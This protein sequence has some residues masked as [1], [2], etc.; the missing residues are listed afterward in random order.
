MVGPGGVCLPLGLEWAGLL[1]TAAER[2]K[3]RV[4]GLLQDHSQT[5]VCRP[6]SKTQR[7]MSP[8]GPLGRQDYS[9]P[10]AERGCSPDTGHFSICSPTEV[11]R[12]TYR[13]TDG[14]ASCQVPCQMVLM[15][16][17]R[18]NGA[19][20]ES[21]GC[22]QICNQDH[23]WWICHLDTCLPSQM[24]LLHL[25]LH[26]GFTVSSLDPTGLPHRHF[27]LGKAAKLLLLRGNISGGPP[28]SPFC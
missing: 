2:G 20:A 8:G 12:P 3:N 18:P 14:H 7:G 16:G 11:D 6:T 23:S 28:I 13:D 5:E 17:S 21:T 10:V 27:C 9:W 26:Q 1:L 4:I 15:A 24:G 25:R 19:V 22:F